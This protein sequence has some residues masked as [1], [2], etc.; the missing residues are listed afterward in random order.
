MNGLRILLGALILLFGRRL[1]W[2]A[3]GMLGFLFGFDW[4][5]SRLGDWPAWTAWLAAVGF[6][7]LCAL[8][9]I[10]LQRV[11]FGIGGFLAG[12]YLLV[13]LLTALGVQHA[14]APG[15]LF[16]LGGLAGAVLAVVFVD[17][18]LVALTSLAGA[19]AATEG[20][21]AGPS[22]SILVFFG[23]AAIGMTVQSATLRGTEGRL[24]RPRRRG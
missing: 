5:T 22:G 10:F 23:L 16:L 11:S 2:L 15:V 18:V 17:W 3:V 8:G 24:A 13:R 14:P 20:I 7:T 4:I 9:A 1:F 19:A 12:G 21:G 6:G